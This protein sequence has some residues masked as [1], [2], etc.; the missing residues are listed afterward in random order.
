MMFPTV[1][2]VTPKASAIF[3]IGIPLLCIC[4][5]AAT[6]LSVNFAPG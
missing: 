1:P 3:T 4:L 6:F 2:L 5:I